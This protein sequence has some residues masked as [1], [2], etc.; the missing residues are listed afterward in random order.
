VLTQIDAV[1]LAR[2]HIV[3]ERRRLHLEQERGR[4]R[5]R[6]AS[7]S[8]H[9]RSAQQQL[10]Q[11]QQQHQLLQHQLSEVKQAAG[12]AAAAATTLRDAAQR[13]TQQLP[14]EDAP[15]AP[16]PRISP[17]VE[18]VQFGAPLQVG[19]L[20]L[21]PRVMAP[22]GQQLLPAPQDRVNQLLGNSQ[23]VQQLIERRDVLAP[24]V[25]LAAAE[26]P[27]VAR[28]LAGYVGQRDFATLV[29][30]THGGAQALRQ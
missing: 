13:H 2:Y 17:P 20:L 15:G 10:Q 23:Q 9:L 5:S 22:G 28:C 25:C 14:L 6:V 26:C 18:G 29:A 21:H 1:L 16:L 4:L 11:A 7:L 27:D 24:L 12:R 19:L 3:N 30:A 8:G